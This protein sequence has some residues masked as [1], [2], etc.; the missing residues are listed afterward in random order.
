M[1]VALLFSVRA[2]L[3][4]VLVAGRKEFLN[5]CGLAGNEEWTSGETVE[6]QRQSRLEQDEFVREGI[7]VIKL[8]EY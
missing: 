1:L 4:D 7:A 6:P 5:Q 3:G 2:H 8:S